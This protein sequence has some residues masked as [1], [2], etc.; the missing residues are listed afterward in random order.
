M[1]RIQDRL[2]FVYLQHASVSRDANA[3]TATDA[4]GT[5]HIPAA[6]VSCLMLGPGTR[7]THQAMT[8][9]GETGASVVWV[10]E[11]G[12][13]YYAGGEPLAR[14]SKLLIAQAKLVSNEKSRIAVARQMYAMR[15][16]GE[17]VSKDSMH[18]LRGK[19]GARV[20][21]AYRDIAKLAGV[22]WAK[23]EYTPGDF[24][25]GTPIN[26]ALTAAHTA[27]YGVVHAVVVALGA[28]PGLGFVHAGNSRS[29]VYDLADLYKTKTSV[30]VAFSVIKEG[31]DD[32]STAVRRAMRDT[33]AKERT[34]ETVVRD[35]KSLLL[36]DEE[37]PE[38]EQLADVVFLWDPLAKVASGANYDDGSGELTW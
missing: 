25:A 21:K 17:D 38:E 8:L 14:S 34:L 30:P 23:R 5:V 19:E 24:E 15:F 9:L 2:T 7:I 3:V 6:Q 16:P 11:S 31:Y 35:M 20:R 28:A 10:G 33:F 36:Q 32:L 29:F 13:R 27:L 26:Q 37:F 18:Q 12:V 22:E 1:A 4:R